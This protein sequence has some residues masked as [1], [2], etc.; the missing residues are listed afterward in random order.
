MRAI[1]FFEQGHA[2]EPEEICILDEGTDRQ[3]SYRQMREM[4]LRIANGLLAEGLGQGRHGAVYSP[5][6]GLG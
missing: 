2:L 3:F 4:T 5:N 6:N 1:D